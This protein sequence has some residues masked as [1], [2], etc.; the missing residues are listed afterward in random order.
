MEPSPS[1][2]T[3]VLGWADESH[4]HPA[5]QVRFL[6]ANGA[7]SGHSAGLV[8]VELQLSAD[9]AAFETSLLC[10]GCDIK[11]FADRLEELHDRLEGSAR[12]VNQE[13]SIQIE[14]SVAD[15]SRGR[16]AVGLQIELIPVDWEAPIAGLLEKPGGRFVLDGLVLEQSYLP[17]IIQQMR[18]FVRDAG[19]STVHPMAAN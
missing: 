2:S 4:T 12:F 14:V 17:D 1:E 3:I 13:G 16:L 9:S 10:F 15:W 7:P 5:L 6:A 8:A 11:D 19:I 18:S